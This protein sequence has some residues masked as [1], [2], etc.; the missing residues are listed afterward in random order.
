MA[1]APV[2]PVEKD[3]G[4]P[5]VGAVGSEIRADM[6]ARPAPFGGNTAV[7]PLLRTAVDTS[8]EDWAP[9]ICL[10]ADDQCLH[11]LAFVQGSPGLAAF[12]PAV[13]V[14]GE[15]NAPVVLVWEKWTRDQGWERQAP[16]GNAVATATAIDPDAADA[17]VTTDFALPFT[18]N[19]SGQ[20]VLFA[21]RTFNR[22]VDNQS[23]TVRSNP[24]LVTVYEEAP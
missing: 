15:L 19:E 1:L 21:E 12:T 4:S 3:T 20:A 17:A 7:P 23:I 2:V 9:A 22:A 6:R 8:R 18:T 11:S 24:V 10:V 13:W 14:A 5:L 16:T